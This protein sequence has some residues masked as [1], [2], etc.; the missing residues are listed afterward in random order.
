MQIKNETLDVEFWVDL[1]FY[2]LEFGILNFEIFFEEQKI[3][4]LKL[5]S[6]FWWCSKQKEKL[7]ILSS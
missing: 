2:F 6:F 4:Y 1:K 7:Y 3:L 5:W